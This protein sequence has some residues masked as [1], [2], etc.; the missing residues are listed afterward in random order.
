MRR[1]F[2]GLVVILSGGLF[3]AGLFM[4]GLFGLGACGYQTGDQPSA[5]QSVTTDTYQDSTTITS[6]PVSIPPEFSQFRGMVERLQAQGVAVA[7]LRLMTSSEDYGTGV[8][9]VLQSNSSGGKGTPEDAIGSRLVFRAAV[10]EKMGGTQI[11]A[12]GVAYLKPSGEIVF[13]H[14]VPIDRTIAAEWYATPGLSLEEVTERATAD[15]SARL[16]SG[17]FAIVEVRATQDPDGTRVL[18]VKLTVPSIAIANE[19]IND[20]SRAIGAAVGALNE[21]NQAKIGVVRTE[22]D[23]SAGEPVLWAIADL[24]L[25]GASHWEAEGITNGA[26]PRPQPAPALAEG[27]PSDFAFVAAYGVGARNIIDTRA[28]K[29][30]KDLVLAGQVTTDLRLSDQ[31]LQS[32]YGQLAEMQTRWQLFTI[33]P[34]TVEADPAGTGTSLFVTPH[35]TY[36]LEWGIGDFR[37]N[38]IVWDDANLSTDPKAVAL[39][40][41]FQ[42]LQEMIE[43]TPEWETL[44]PSEGGY[45]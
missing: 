18:R 40:D 23:T 25:E 39:R 44:P 13:S 24:Q 31:D 3:V 14:V 21:E 1:T 45:A 6:L 32:L 36:R 34:F 41:W 15:I 8:E 28:G 4:G 9:V 38:P 43:A 35:S 11:D 2:R 12:V 29:F 42:K 30:T 16:A 33:S 19:A 26:Y 20:Q 37:Y 22:I 27:M 17:P 5:R 10:L 7:S